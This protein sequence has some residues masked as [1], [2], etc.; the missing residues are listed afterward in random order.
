MTTLP[1]P[2]ALPAK[3]SSPKPNA[4]KE[5]PREVNPIPLHEAVSAIAASSGVEV[6]QF[7]IG[8][9]ADRY[10]VQL[11]TSR[12]WLY[13]RPLEDEEL[14]RAMRAHLRTSQQST[15]AVSLFAS[16]RSDFTPATSVRFASR[17]IRRNEIAAIELD[18]GELAFNSYLKQLS[19]PDGPLTIHCA[20][21]ARTVWRFVRQLSCSPMAPS[22]AF[23]EDGLQLAWTVGAGVL[24]IRVREHDGEWFSRDRLTHTVHSGDLRSFESLPDELVA[25]LS[26]LLAQ[27]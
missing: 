26:E 12:S 19:A 8:S 16:L 20:G 21:N 11:P 18:A 17:T 14:R 13:A 23:S 1:P 22:C 5:D 27:R 3:S 9:I 4:L 15:S 2:S 24:S 6:F 25:C 7:D 10:K